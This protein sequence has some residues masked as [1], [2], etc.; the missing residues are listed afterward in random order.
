MHP[1]TPAGPIG[2]MYSQRTVLSV[3]IEKACMGPN[4]AH[5]PVVQE[6]RIYYK[7]PFKRKEARSLVRVINK[8]THLENFNIFGKVH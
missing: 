2:G 1:Y 7:L 6:A 3:I 5:F 4:S 8:D